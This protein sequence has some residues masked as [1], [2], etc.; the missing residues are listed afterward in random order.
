MCAHI[1][2]PLTVLAG[3]DTLAVLCCLFHPGTGFAAPTITK[4]AKAPQFLLYEVCPRIN[5]FFFVSSQQKSWR[6]ESGLTGWCGE[7]GSTSWCGVSGPTSWCGVSGSQVCKNWESDIR[8]RTTSSVLQASELGRLH[9]WM[10]PHRGTDQSCGDMTH[11]PC[12]E[13]L[14]GAVFAFFSLF[15]SKWCKI[16]IQKRRMISIIRHA[17]WFF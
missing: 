8:G 5:W 9:T 17:S 4:L 6:G 7:V 14:F 15:V 13:S 11:T 12:L 1:W 16:N 10:N 3:V 2:T